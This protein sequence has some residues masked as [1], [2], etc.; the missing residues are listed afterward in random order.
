MTGWARCGVVLVV[1]LGVAPFATATELPA[2][3]FHTPAERA[4]IESQRRGVALPDGGASSGPSA[5]PVTSRDSR[6]ETRPSGQPARDGR[7]LD[8]V[9]VANGVRAIAWIGGRRVEDGALYGVYR[10]RVATSG[11]YLVATDGRRRFV[12]VGKDLEP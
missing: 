6:S 4:A 7:R 9:A 3:V 5:A 10:L 12:Q 11:V 1:L 8:G 2:R